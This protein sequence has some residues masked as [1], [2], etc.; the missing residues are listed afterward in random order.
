[1]AVEHFRVVRSLALEGTDLTGFTGELI[2][3]ITNGY[4]VHWNITGTWDYEDPAIDPEVFS[5]EATAFPMTEVTEVRI[6]IDEAR[7]A[8]PAILIIEAAMTSEG[9]VQFT[10][11]ERVRLQVAYDGTYQVSVQ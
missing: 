11:A 10:G 5:A 1:M 3:R 7:L 6:P 8:S 9:P 4:P 2:V